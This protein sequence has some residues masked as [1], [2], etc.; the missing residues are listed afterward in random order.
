MDPNSHLPPMQPTG[1]AYPEESDRGLSEIT[2]LVLRETGI[3]LSEY[4]A[5]TVSRRVATRL[6][7]VNCQD[8]A[9]YLHLLESDPTE[10]G[11]LLAHLTIKWSRFFRDPQ[12]FSLLGTLLLQQLLDGGEMVRIWSAGCGRGEEPYS[13]AMLLMEMEGQVR[14]G[15]WI[16]DATDVDALALEDAA[17]RSYSVRSVAGVPDRVVESYFSQHVARTGRGYRLHDDV[18]QYVSFSHHD[19]LGGKPRPLAPFD[20]VLCRNVT[21]YFE[22]GA[23]GRVFDLLTSS[24]APGGYLCLGEAEQLPAVYSREF[25]TLDRK[26]RIYRR[27]R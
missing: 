26:A 2:A 18:G 9:Q 5:S 22:A 24:V 25:D 7:T 17:M 15:R 11:H 14:S 10:A 3:D 20:L 23:H 21:I 12:C 4:R 8:H 13:L 1:Q 19:L 6:R 16:I 27:K